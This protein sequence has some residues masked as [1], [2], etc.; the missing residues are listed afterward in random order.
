MIEFPEKGLIFTSFLSLTA[1]S[2]ALKTRETV[3]IS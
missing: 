2:L 3:K 1:A